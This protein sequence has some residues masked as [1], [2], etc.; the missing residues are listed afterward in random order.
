MRKPLEYPQAA[1]YGR[2]IQFL[3]FQARKTKPTSSITSFNLIMSELVRSALVCLHHLRLPFDKP[4]MRF[5]VQMENLGLIVVALPNGSF[6]T[7]EVTHASS[8][9]G[10]VIFFEDIVAIAPDC[11]EA[12][13]R[14]AQRAIAL[15]KIDHPVILGVAR[16]QTTS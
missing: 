16:S 14:N 1:Q 11:R 5:Q 10:T 3:F 9:V 12:A 6:D 13:Y 15:Y 8:E 4:E 7:R 2:N